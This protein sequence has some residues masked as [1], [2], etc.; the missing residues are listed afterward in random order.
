MMVIENKYEFGQIVY[1]V[2][3][4]EQLPRM[5]TGFTIRPTGVLYLCQSGITETAH[6][7]MELQGEKVV[8]HLF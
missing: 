5:V 3:D 1:L 4:K 2:T 6:Y 7:E 8:E